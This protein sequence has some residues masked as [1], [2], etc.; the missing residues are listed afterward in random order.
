MKPIFILG[1]GAQK[2]GTSWLHA[3]LN[4]NKNVNMGIMKEYHVWD[5]IYLETFRELKAD[6]ERDAPTEVVRG[7]MQAE[8]GVYIKYFQELINSDVR[9]TGD[10][11][12]SY[13]LLDEGALRE[14]AQRIED[15]GFEPK[16]IYLMRDPVERMWS[17]ARMEGR[18]RREMGYQL[19]E[20]VVE[21]IVYGYLE[22]EAQMARSDYKTAV[23][24]IDRVLSSDQVHFEIYE[25]LFKNSSIERLCAFLGFPL[26]NVNF[27]QRVN[28]SPVFA[29]SEKTTRDIMRKMKPQY[30]FCSDRFPITNGLWQSGL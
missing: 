21:E 9:V 7:R 12:P 25:N 28:A 13:A 11:T 10:I 27:D 8:E 22:D 4:K 24:T 23:R 14:I 17:A 2:S 26:E 19:D 18:T 16:V 5:Y 20:S 3:T 30:E 6:I 15:G 1:L 29:R